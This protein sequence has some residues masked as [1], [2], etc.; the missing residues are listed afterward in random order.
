MQSLKE[1]N[2]LRYVLCPKRMTDEEFWKVYFTLAKKHLPDEA[3]DLEFEPPPDPPAGGA[4]AARP[5]NVAGLQKSLSQVRAHL[6]I[7]LLS[8][9]PYQFSLHDS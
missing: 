9:C 8:S 1:I 4:P 5:F 3:W 6:L 2:E 7:Y